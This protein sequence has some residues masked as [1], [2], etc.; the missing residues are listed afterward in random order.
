MPVKTQSWH[1]GSDFFLI[2]QI[3]INKNRCKGKCAGYKC[4]V[5]KPY[6]LTWCVSVRYKN[7]KEKSFLISL[8]GL[9]SGAYG[10]R[11]ITAYNYLA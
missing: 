5:L 10:E 11:T 9:V 4:A 8:F 3:L 2:E 6:G 7:K 1:K